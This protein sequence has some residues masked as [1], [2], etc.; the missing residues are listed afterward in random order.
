MA[1]NREVFVERGSGRML[2]LAEVHAW[3]DRSIAGQRTLHAPLFA[4]LGT[5]P[6]VE[7]ADAR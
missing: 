2:S 5:P 3:V 1:L 4:A 6:V 7:V